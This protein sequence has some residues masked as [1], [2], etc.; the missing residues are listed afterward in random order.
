MIIRCCAI[1]S[2]LLIISIAPAAATDPWDEYLNKSYQY[3]KTAGEKWVSNNKCVSCHTA[4]PYFMITPIKSGTPEPSDHVF[5]TQVFKDAKS[6]FHKIKNNKTDSNVR[7]I[8]AT[9]AALALNDIISGERKA[10]ADTKKALKWMWILQDARFGNW[11]WWEAGGWPP[12]EIRPRYFGASLAYIAA[13]R[14]KAELGEPYPEPKMAHLIGYLR[15]KA[16]NQQGN[17]K[18][19]YLNRVTML[20]WANNYFPKGGQ[21]LL[22]KPQ[23]ETFIQAM[24]EAQ[25]QNSGGWSIDT[26]NDWNCQSKLPG[27][28]AHAWSSDCDGKNC[29]LSESRHS[30]KWLNGWAFSVCPITCK[31]G[32]VNCPGRRKNP[33]AFGTGLITY[34]L[35]VSLRSGVYPPNSILKASMTNS[36]AKGIGWLKDEK[37]WV[38]SGKDIDGISMD[39]TWISKSRR[40]YSKH[41]YIRRAATAFG[42]LAAT[43]ARGTKNSHAEKKK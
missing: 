10:R 17:L 12:F 26:L 7:I 6:R 36:I 39:G 21:P 30:T 22:T 23:W 14:A 33:D 29:W 8:V 31:K 43:S 35:Q 41:G 4:L 25:D 19:S 16:N 28:D 13:V 34:V 3:V 38:R 5:R 2:L 42:W 27:I 20:V 37:N 40:A 15:S 1:V 9:A 11:T 32:G 24:V 18:K